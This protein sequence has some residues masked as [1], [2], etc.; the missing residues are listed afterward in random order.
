MERGKRRE[1]NLYED[2]CNMSIE[3]INRILDN[4]K[5]DKIQELHQKL[6]NNMD[7]A[8]KLANENTIRNEQGFVV[9]SKDDEWIS[10]DD[11]SENLEK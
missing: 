10:E 8:V 7:K 4:Y 6:N 3:E 11:Y 2:A 5:T 1:L 9:V